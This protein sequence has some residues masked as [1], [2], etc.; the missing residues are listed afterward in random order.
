MGICSSIAILKKKIF[1]ASYESW[2]LYA[3]GCFCVL[4]KWLTDGHT[5]SERVSGF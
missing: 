4:G 1:R 3:E 5:Y 2:K